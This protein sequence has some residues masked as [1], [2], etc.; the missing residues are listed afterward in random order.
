MV[1]RPG[2]RTSVS[3]SELGPE[4][5]GPLFPIAG[6]CQSR[7]FA[8][9]S[10]LLFGVA[11]SK[12]FDGPAPAGGVAN[13]ARA[14]FARMGEILEAA[15]LGRGDVCFVNVYLNDV[16][17]DVADF[18]AEWRAYFKDL[19]PARCC[20]GATLQPSILVEMVFV[21]QAPRPAA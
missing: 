7:A 12:P 21:A 17:A 9:D 20:V 19:A 5:A 2:T 1:Q 15:G 6:R 16:V 3:A 10:G 8:V 4:L 18:N 13:H 11:A 14:A